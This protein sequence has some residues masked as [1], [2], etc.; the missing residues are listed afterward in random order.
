MTKPRRPTE[1][2]QGLV[3]Q[4]RLRVVITIQL[5]VLVG[6]CALVWGLLG[7]TETGLAFAIIGVLVIAEV[8]LLIRF[9][10]EPPESDEATVKPLVDNS[11]ETVLEDPSGGTIVVDRRAGEVRAR[12]GDLTVRLDDARAVHIDLAE[13]CKLLLST[14]RDLVLVTE[15]RDSLPRE[16]AKLAAIGRLLARAAAVPFEGE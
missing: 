5:V 9:L 12:N 14:R 3:R 10:R 7:R 2:V 6:A 13:H 16:R 15:I 8:G 1:H 4:S 11:D